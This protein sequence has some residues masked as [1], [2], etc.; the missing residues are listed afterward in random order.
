MNVTVE[1]EIGVM[2]STS[3]GTPKDCWLEVR[4]FKAGGP[5]NTLILDFLPPEM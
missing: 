4:R 3:Q 2:Q 1:A 5:A